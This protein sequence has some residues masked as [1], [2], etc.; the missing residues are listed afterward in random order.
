MG[1]VDLSLELRGSLGILRGGL[2]QDRPFA[3]IPQEEHG[4][5]RD[6]SVKKLLSKM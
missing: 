5:I 4:T 1:K 2:P 6:S 3:H